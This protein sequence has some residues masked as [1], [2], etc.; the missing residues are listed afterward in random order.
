MR[1]TPNTVQEPRRSIGILLLR[2]GIGAVMVVAGIVMLVVDP[3]GLGVDGF[4]MAAG[5]GLSVLLVNFLYRLGVS[6]DTERDEEERARAYF[7][8]HGEWPEEEQ[9]ERGRRW[10]LAPGV[11]TAD[12][13]PREQDR[14]R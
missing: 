8:E 14:R 7:D 11:Q 5:G 3:S 10:A 12:D 13:E 6:G 2:Y 9:R 4:A 1:Q